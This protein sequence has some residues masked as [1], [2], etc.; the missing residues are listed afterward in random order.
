MTCS[1]YSVAHLALVRASAR[2]CSAPAFKFHVPAT[3]NGKRI[4]SSRI[5]LRLAFAAAE[6]ARDT[7]GYTLH[8]SLLRALG[9]QSQAARARV[10]ACTQ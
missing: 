7:G 4:D 10:G 8:L 9:E 6:A 5:G 2:L 1:W 3:W